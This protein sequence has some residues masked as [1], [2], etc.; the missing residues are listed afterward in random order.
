MADVIARSKGYFG[1]EIR[2]VG[3]RFDVPDEIWNDETRRPKWA[4]PAAFG[5][6][7]DHDGDG[8]AGGS[9]PVNTAGV[10][11]VVVSPDWRNGNAS[12]R[13]ALAKQ[14]SG[15]AV[16]NAKEA[17]EIIE[18]YVAANAPAPFSD[19]PAPETAAPVRAKS[20]I[21]D[22]LGTT[23]P[24]WIAPSAAVAAED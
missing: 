3:D 4:A 12:E 7:G 15:Q 1:G 5:G 10:E 18:A 11:A 2:E 24:D 19:A 6:K 23:A 17:D 21:N 8:K 14:I 16:P 13:K 20:E 9:V 22:A